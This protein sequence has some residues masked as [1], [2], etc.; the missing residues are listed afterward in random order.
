[1]N[2]DDIKEIIDLQHLLVEH[3]A[4]SDQEHD[5]KFLAA[6]INWKHRE[7]VVKVTVSAAPEP[8]KKGSKLVV[9]N[10]NPVPDEDPEAF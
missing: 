8:A 3:G 10:T 9:P 2:A 5:H 6:L 7:P 4:P 1:M